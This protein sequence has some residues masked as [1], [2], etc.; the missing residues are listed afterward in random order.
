MLTLE[1]GRG[2]A[3]DGATRDGALKGGRDSEIGC[4]TGSSLVSRRKRANGLR[5]TSRGLSNAHCLLEWCCVC[6]RRLGAC[7]VSL[8]S[9]LVELLL[10]IVEH[11]FIRKCGG[12]GIF[13]GNPKLALKRLFLKDPSYAIIYKGVGP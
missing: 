12:G 9:P 3:L 6:R 2:T 1:D 4:D 7:S 11:T 10:L 13:G 5:D 8:S